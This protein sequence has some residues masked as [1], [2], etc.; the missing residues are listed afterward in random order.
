MTQRE[1]TLT[2]LLANHARFL[3]FLEPRL[4]GRE[5]AEDVLQAAF[6]K[7]LTKADELRDGEITADGAPPS[8]AASSG[9]RA[10]CR[11][12]RTTGRCDGRSASVRAA[13]KK[14]LEAACGTCTEHGCLECTCEE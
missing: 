10:A 9:M 2:T 11:M 5:A 7:G 6:V 4:G 3:A 1:E 14:Q 13:L 8:S 12:W